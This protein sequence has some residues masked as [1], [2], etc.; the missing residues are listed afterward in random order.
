MKLVCQ[1]DYPD[2][3]YLTN[4]AHDDIDHNTT[5]KES[6]CGV[7]C[8]K[9]LIDHYFPEKNISLEDTIQI[10]YDAGAN[11]SAGTNF[12]RLGKK[13]CE[14]FDLEYVPTDDDSLLKKHLEEGDLAVIN[15]GGDHDDHIGIFS[16]IGHYVLAY[17]MNNNEVK[18]LDPGYREGKYSTIPRVDKVR[19]EEEFVVCDLSTL[20][21]DTRNRQVPYFLFKRK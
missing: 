10:A 6:G 21:E 20:M 5:I 15:V 3:I 2:M 14:M 12:V 8:A 9:M 18:V 1:N 7:C 16:N 13:M 4:L 19:I 11:Y 17:S